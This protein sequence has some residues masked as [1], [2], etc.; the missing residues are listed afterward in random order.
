MLLLILTRLVVLPFLLVFFLVG[1]AQHCDD[2]PEKRP[3]GSLDS[4]CLG[5][6]TDAGFLRQDHNRMPVLILR[7]SGGMFVNPTLQNQS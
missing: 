1:K 3:R 5:G 4:T 7:S 2:V 6:D